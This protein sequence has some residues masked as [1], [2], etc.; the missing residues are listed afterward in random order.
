ML[1]SD[2]VAGKW[3]DNEMAQDGDSQ[4]TGFSCSTIWR[5]GR[6]PTGNNQ[7]P[8]EG[9]SGFSDMQCTL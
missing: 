1:E 9:Y 2:L 5:Y 3:H 8:Q 6:R 4:S 7:F